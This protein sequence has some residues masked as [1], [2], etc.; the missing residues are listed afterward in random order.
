MVGDRRQA[1]RMR[2]AESIARRKMLVSSMAEEVGVRHWGKSGGGFERTAAGIS[3]LRKKWRG[4]G[5]RWDIRWKNLQKM[6]TSA[7]RW[8]KSDALESE[9][10]KEDRDAR[11]KKSG[12][13]EGDKTARWKDQR[14]EERAVAA[15][16]FSSDF[17]YTIFML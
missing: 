3:G 16:D 13:R 8:K 11:E 5:I 9:L 2:T 4:E 10:G 14:K 15:V 1:G 12:H 6:H 7:R 17:L